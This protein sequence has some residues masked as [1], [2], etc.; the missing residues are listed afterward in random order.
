MSQKPTYKELEDRIQELEKA[1][2][3]YRQKL[4][5]LDKRNFSYRDIFEAVNDGIFIHD[6]QDGRILD[7]NQRVADMY[8]YNKKEII[9]LDI[10]SLSQGIAPYSKPEIE[11]N[12]KKAAMGEQHLFEWRAK[13]KNGELFW[14]E[15]NLKIV[16]FEDQEC[17]IAIVRDIDARIKTEEALRFTQY[18]ID[19]TID[20]AF[21][22]T[23][24]GH[25][26]YVNDATCKALGYTQEELLNLS[27]SDIDPTSSF[28][29]YSKYWPNLKKNGSA[30][31]ESFLRRK[32]GHE[33][34]VE[35]RANYVAFGDKEYNCAFATNITDRIKMEN[36]LKESEGFLR[37]LLQTIPDLVWLKDTKGVFLACNEAF[38]RFIGNKEEDIVGNTDY[39]LMDKDMADFFRE[40]D[41][42]A[43][44]AGKPSI[45]EEWVTFA[46]DGKRVLLE[47]IKTPMRDN[48]GQLI[49]VLGV[50]RD[51]TKRKMAED[52][53]LE[54][55]RKLF[56]LMSNLPGMAY[57]CKND[58]NW[59][60]E[61]VSDGCMPLTGYSADE[62][63]SSSGIPYADL[64]NSEDRLSV[65]NIVQDKLKNKVPFKFVYRITDANG[66]EKWVW[67]QGQGIFD[68]KGNVKALEGFIIDI[69]E[70]ILAET[71][72]KQSEELSN[73]IQRL[74]KIGAWEWDIASKKVF[75]TGEV[76]R[77]HEMEPDKEVHDMDLTI[78]NSLSCYSD[79]DRR[80]IWNALS[81]CAEEGIPYTFEFPFTTKKGRKIWIQTSAKRVQDQN[82][83]NRVIGYIM[84]ITER[85]SLESQ[86]R[87][88]Q[89]M[90]SIGRLAGGVAHD[91]N[92]MLSV[93]LG[94]CEMSLVQPGIHGQIKDSIHEIMKA[95]RRS[96]EITRQL[97]AFARRQTISPKLT[98]MNK[99]ISNMLKI[100]QRLIGEDIDLLWLPNETVWPVMIDPA[101]I[102]QILANLCVNARDALVGV[103]KITIETG[104]VEFDESYCE[105]H[106]GFIPGEYVLLVVS[107]NGCGMD[108]ETMNNIFDPFF[109]T[110]ESGKGTGLGLATVYGI[111]KQNNGFINIY[112]EL[113]HGT[114]FKIYLPRYRIKDI[115]LLDKIKDQPVVGGQETILVVED[116]QAILEVIERM[117]KD[118]GYKVLTA[119]TPG[120]A[121]KCARVH[122][123]KIHL[124]LTDLVMPEMNGRDLTKVILSI[125]PDIR[126][127]YMSGYTANVIAHQGI[128]DK[129]INYIQKP[130]SKKELGAKIREALDEFQR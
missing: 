91:F 19:K 51:I 74:G 49:G 66:L 30:T 38:E 31:F 10:E 27:I 121:I 43:V 78:E 23:R 14:V 8:G 48:K 129:G 126:Q 21:W 70:R 95:A 123:R 28:N 85:H 99:A 18:T 47:T 104:N 7:V 15:V 42:K 2:S 4:D 40:Y 111:V 127:L 88:A 3:E 37:S 12:I 100:L 81:K 101:Q 22:T 33:Y 6:A 45:N 29:K 5:M 44:T 122:N 32:D 56:T 50:A 115:S 118:F 94:H 98:D 80:V 46:Y 93:I 62:L 26:F 67:E 97:L 79:E 82:G 86:L 130:F 112:S 76:Y 84:D 13:K 34:P 16:T 105:D 77:I 64:I 69:S 125:H 96:A 53:L 71:K 59:T 9:K 55:Q 73:S 54:S 41:R 63:V 57:R 106:A 128:L 68:E 119:G 107:D 35:I 11:K 90:E 24:D 61:F 52:A 124:L 83:D 114:T 116:E 75:W 103:G 92:N 17:V 72:L 25:L 110:K 87:Q 36:S 60:I 120:E 89:K 117:L 58:S 108:A 109:T 65:W 1:E 113:N 39:D 102:D 20:Q